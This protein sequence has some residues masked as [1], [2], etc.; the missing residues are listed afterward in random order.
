[1][2]QLLP[3]RRVLADVRLR[4]PLR[5]LADRRL[6]P[7]TTRRAQHAHPGPPLPPR[8]EDP[9]RRDRDVPAPPGQHRALPL[10]GRTH[11]DP[12]VER[13]NN[14]TCRTGG[15]NTWRAG[16]GG[17]RTSGSE[18]GPGK[19]IHR[20]M[21]RAPRS[22]PYTEHRSDEGKVYLAV[23]LDAFSRRVVGWS[24]ADHLRA[25]LVADALQMATW[26][27]QPPDGQTIAH[28]D[29]GGQY[30]SWLF[31]TRLREAG[32]LGS[33]GTVGD[34]F[35]NSVA[36]AFFS[37]LPRELLD[38]HHWATRSQLATAIFEWIECWYNPHRRHSYNNGLSPIDY[39]TTNA[40]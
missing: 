34:C 1:M 32:L 20:K 7:Q 14:R 23:V 15:M 2:V 37:S 25:E 31:G 9:R 16:C 35:D 26:R 36:E 29:H 18:G 19:T 4:R 13:N 5:L 28:S 10:P 12:L 6:A 39:E 38:Q 17:S 24:S 30:V 3:S 40:A 22:D 21:G 33:M 8:L 11:P 27:R